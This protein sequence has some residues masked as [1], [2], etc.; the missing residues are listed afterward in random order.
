MENSRGQS[1]SL[2]QNYN[3]PDA[4][5]THNIAT[6]PAS[7]LKLNRFDSFGANNSLRDPTILKQNDQ[8]N[9]YIPISKLSSLQQ[10]NKASSY[11]EN[12]SN[13]SNEHFARNSGGLFT[14]SKKT[15]MEQ[16]ITP[17]KGYSRLSLNFSKSKKKV[18]ST[19]L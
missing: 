19:S 9:A 15:S 16:K 18:S 13:I 17:T 12:Y 1:D 5:K 2:N 8:S 6:Q 14:L 11:V 10:N 4:F 7:D 3:T